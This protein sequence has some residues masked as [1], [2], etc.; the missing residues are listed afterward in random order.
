MESNE[1]GDFLDEVIELCGCLLVVDDHIFS[2][3]FKGYHDL[4]QLMRLQEM[5]QRQRRLGN[6]LALN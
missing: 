2:E 1:E 6:P 5:A 4:V 3:I